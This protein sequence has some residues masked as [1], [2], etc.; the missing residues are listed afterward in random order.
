MIDVSWGE[1]LVVTGIG[2]YVIGKKDLPAAARFGGSQVGRLVGFLQGARARA[3]RFASDSELYK[4]RNELRSGMRELD[5]VKSELAMASSSQGIIGR[6]LGSHNAKPLS[7]AIHRNVIDTTAANI[8]ISNQSTLPS[9]NIPT[10]ST[11]PPPPPPPFNASKSQSIAA[12][13]EEEWPKQGIGFKSR[14]EIGYNSNDTAN[15]GS[16]ILSDI[17]KESLIYDQY[18]R[19]VQE[20]DDIL[21][22]KIHNVANDR[23]NK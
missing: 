17:I 3:D 16:V 8:P 14:A 6:E 22:S 4:L 23:K 18:Q 20:Q 5:A 12:I 19:V 15:S 1:I 7:N 21:K 10:S 2:F 9:I 13:A 11:P